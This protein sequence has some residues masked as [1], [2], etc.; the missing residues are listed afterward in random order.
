MCVHHA[1]S[2]ARPTAAPLDWCVL[3]ARQL[4]SDPRFARVTSISLAGLPLYLYKVGR[5]SHE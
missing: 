5:A 3:K 1:V 4:L 2:S